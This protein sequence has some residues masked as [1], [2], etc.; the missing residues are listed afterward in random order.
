MLKCLI[1]SVV[2]FRIATNVLRL[3]EG[4]LTDDQNSQQFQWQLL[5]KRCYLLG[6]LSA[7]TLKEIR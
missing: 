4:C 6:G 3:G 1:C 7:E 5:P 2:S